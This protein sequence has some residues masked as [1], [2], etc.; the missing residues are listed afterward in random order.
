MGRRWCRPDHHRQRDGRRPRHDRAGWRGVAG[1]PAT[2]QIQALGACGAIR[3]CAVLA[4]DQSPRPADAGQ[5]WAKNL[6]TFSRAAGAWQ[7]VQAFCHAVCND[8]WRDR[9]GYPALCQYRTPRRARRVHWRGN[10]RC[11]WLFTEPV[12]VAVDQPEDGRVGRG[13][14]KQGTPV[15]RNRQGGQGCGFCGFC[16][17]GQAQLG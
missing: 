15:A 11:P 2:A 3:R 6:G 8:P 14:G 13:S 7:A 5:P 17:G 4:A 1:R 10:P 16:S 12:P 9:R